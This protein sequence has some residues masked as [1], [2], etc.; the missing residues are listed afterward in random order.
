[1]KWKSLYHLFDPQSFLKFLF[2]KNNK[3]T[4]CFNNQ[5]FPTNSSPSNES[6]IFHAL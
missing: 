6:F 5:Q 1:M 4:I 3:D 2:T